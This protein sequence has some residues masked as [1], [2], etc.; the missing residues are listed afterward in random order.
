MAVGAFD[1]GGIEGDDVHEHPEAEFL[2]EEA[3]S[4]PE[5]GETDGGVEEELDRVVAG[6]AVDIDSAGEVRGFGVVQ[7]VV[8]GEPGIGMG[9]GDD[10]TAARVVESGGLEA[11]VVEDL[12]YAG[13]LTTEL[14]DL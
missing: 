1:Q 3:L 5:F 14:E 12:F 7:P 11:S 9:Q 4:D 8:V 10:I 13:G 6:F 2:L